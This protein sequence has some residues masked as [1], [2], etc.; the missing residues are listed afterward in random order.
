MNIAQ[1]NRIKTGVFQISG[2]DVFVFIWFYIQYNIPVP[3]DYTGDIP[4]DNFLH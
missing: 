1:Y 4:K 2:L 3:R